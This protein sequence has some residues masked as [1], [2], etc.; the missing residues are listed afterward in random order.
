MAWIIQGPGLFNNGSCSCC[1][2]LEELQELSAP[3][4]TGILIWIFGLSVEITADLQKQ[5]LNSSRKTRENLF[6]RDL[7]LVTAPELFREINC[8]SESRQL[9]L[10]LCQVGN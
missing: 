6:K 4:I 3:E 8:G 9:P 5:F 2:D 10:S 7:E 1:L